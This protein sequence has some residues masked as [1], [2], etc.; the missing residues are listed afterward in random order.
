MRAAMS[1]VGANA[2]PQAAKLVL[3]PRL[4]SKADTRAKLQTP[5]NPGGQRIRG[6]HSRRCRQKG[7]SSKNLGG[8][9]LKDQGTAT[10]LLGDSAHAAVYEGGPAQEEV[11]HQEERAAYSDDTAST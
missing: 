8:G 9:K 4:L 1:S 10:K 6:G 7:Q 3:L 11:R 2:N 5:L